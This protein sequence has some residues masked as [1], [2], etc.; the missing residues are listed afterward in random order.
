MVCKAFPFFIGLFWPKLQSGNHR[1][2]FCVSNR[3]LRQ[4][5]ST[6]EDWEHAK[7]QRTSHSSTEMRQWEAKV[8]PTSYAFILFQCITS[9][10]VSK[11]VTK[12]LSVC[13]G[14][15]NSRFT[16]HTSC[17]TCACRIID[18]RSDSVLWLAAGWF[19]F[20]SYNFGL[21]LANKCFRFLVWF[22]V[23]SDVTVLPGRGFFLDKRATDVITAWLYTVWRA[24][25][26]QILG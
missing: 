1:N 9:E 19:H 7:F 8:T 14:N 17:V 15:R 13:F 6:W 23:C 24:A 4:G 12:Q 25:A 20:C 10:A 3:S 16:L 22:G 11:I 26:M 5:R 21:I 18:F 2:N